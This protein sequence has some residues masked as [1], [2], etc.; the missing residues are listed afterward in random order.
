MVKGDPEGSGIRPA[1][2][3]PF[4]LRFSALKKWKREAQRQKEGVEC[5]LSGLSLPGMEVL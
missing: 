5:D 4:D 2:S 3:F 1:V